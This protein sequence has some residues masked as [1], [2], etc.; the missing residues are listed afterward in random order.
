MCRLAVFCS[1][2]RSQ[3]AELAHLSV[4]RPVWSSSP[5][6]SFSPERLLSIHVGPLLVAFWLCVLRFERRP[7][8]L[9]LGLRPNTKISTQIRTIGVSL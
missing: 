6:V 7:A 4:L 2:S 5:R 1:P 3:L 8:A 9:V